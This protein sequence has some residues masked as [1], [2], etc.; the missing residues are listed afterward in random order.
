MIKPDKYYLE[1]I[2]LDNNFVLGVLDKGLLIFFSNR[3]DS[4]Q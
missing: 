1:K 4:I 2:V 3:R